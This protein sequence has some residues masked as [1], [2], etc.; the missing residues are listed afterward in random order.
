V[1]AVDHAG[2]EPRCARCDYTLDGDEEPLTKFSASMF[3]T[4]LSAANQ[5][6]PALRGTS[7]G[8]QLAMVSARQA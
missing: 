3:R 7:T 6:I 4:K 1:V 2:P 8:L 5:V